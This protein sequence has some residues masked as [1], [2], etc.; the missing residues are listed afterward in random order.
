MS[1][2]TPPK[3]VSVPHKD[4]VI[5]FSKINRISNWQHEKKDRISVWHDLGG[6]THEI[7]ERDPIHRNIDSNFDDDI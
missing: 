4:P 2:L 5:L 6:V 7:R 3:P 1:C